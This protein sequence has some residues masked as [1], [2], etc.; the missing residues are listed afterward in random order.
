MYSKEQIQ[1]MILMYKEKNTLKTI[2]QKFNLC[3]ETVSKLLKQNGVIPTKCGYTNANRYSKEKELDI[4]EKYKRGATQ[5]QIAIE[6]NTSNTAIRRVLIRNGIIPRSPSKVQRVCK[7]NPFRRND[8]YSEYFLGLLITDGCISK[9]TGGYNTYTV[10]LS[11][12]SSDGYMIEAFR[13]WASP[14]SKVSKIY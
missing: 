10:S 3:T 12:T 9:H 5:K 4:I 11:L 7:H 8:E 14:K 2:A 6:Y 1:E 13:D